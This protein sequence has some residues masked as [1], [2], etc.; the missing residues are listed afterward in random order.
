MVISPAPQALSHERISQLLTTRSIGRSLIILQDTDSTNSTAFELAEH[1]TADGTV[2]LA[3]RQSAGRGRHGRRWF[4]PSGK[5][6]YG[7]ILLLPT[8]GTEFQQPSL[9]ILPL[10]IGVAIRQTLEDKTRLSPTLKWPNDI[11]LQDKK[12]AG[13]LCEQRRLSSQQSCLV[14]GFG[15][16][17]NMDQTDFPEELRGLATS[18]AIVAGRPLERNALIAHLLD[19]IEL[20]WIH[21]QQNP[22][23]PNL[24]TYRQHCTTLGSLVRVETTPGE[25]VEGEVVKIDDEGSLHLQPNQTHTPKSP[26]IIRSGEIFHLRIQKE[27][28]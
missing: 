7:S 2:V 8:R 27:S 24:E 11:L 9:S 22:T 12:V 25:W 26:L 16:N 18:L 20:Q 15:V 1:G 5:N 19:T 10:L 4:S 28:T 13:V 6:L 23:R 14:I 17:I 3:E 21:Y